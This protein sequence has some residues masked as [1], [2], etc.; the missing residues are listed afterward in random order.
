MSYPNGLVKL[1]ATGPTYEL[2]RD[3]ILSRWAPPR[4]GDMSV[5]RNAELQD[6]RLGLFTY[7][8][9]GVQRMIIQIVL[10]QMVEDG[11]LEKVCRGTF[12]VALGDSKISN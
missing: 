10:R 8:T 5:H 9:I 2:F 6:G 12:R 3:R 7:Q 1:Y 4:K 11:V